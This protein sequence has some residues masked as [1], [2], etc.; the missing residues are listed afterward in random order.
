MNQIINQMITQPISCFRGGRGLL[1]VGSGN[2]EEKK[3]KNMTH[4][5]E[6]NSRTT[7]KSNK[8]INIPPQKGLRR[9]IESSN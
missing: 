2:N 7:T 8:M 6:E 5:H 4:E 1:H 9:S 3:K